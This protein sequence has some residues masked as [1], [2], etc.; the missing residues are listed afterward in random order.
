MF[1]QA[2]GEKARFYELNNSHRISVKGVEADGGK[3][4]YDTLM[5]TYSVLSNL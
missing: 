4:E 1:A 3:K 5:Q 2:R